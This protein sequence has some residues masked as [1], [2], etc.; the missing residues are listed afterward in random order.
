MAHL[1]RSFPWRTSALL[2]EP[3]LYG[4]ILLL[5]EFHGRGSGSSS[6]VFDSVIAAE[7]MHTDFVRP[8]SM[9]PASHWSTLPTFIQAA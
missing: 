8:S 6:R 3:R 5:P 9:S 7:I 4:R 1:L 2:S